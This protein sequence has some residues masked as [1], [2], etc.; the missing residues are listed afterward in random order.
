MRTRPLATLREVL[1]FWKFLVVDGVW[2]IDE[3]GVAGD[4]NELNGSNFHDVCLTGLLAYPVAL[5]A[6]RQL[7]RLATVMSRTATA[8]R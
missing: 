3:N 6:N 2:Q 7:G 5:I 1:T 4:I 8:E